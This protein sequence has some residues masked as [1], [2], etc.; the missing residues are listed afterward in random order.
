MIYLPYLGEFLGAAILIFIGCSVNANVN[1]SKTKGNGA[2]WVVIT[3]GWAVAVMVPV[4]IFDHISGAHFNP[5]VTIGLAIAGEFPWESVAL[6]IVCQMGGAIVGGI[7]T[8]LQFRLHFDVTENKDTQLGVFSTSPAIRSIVDNFISEFLGSFILVFAICGA[9]V[10]APQIA[11]IDNT[12]VAVAGIILAIGMGIGG[13]TG[14]A[15]NPARDLGPRIA[16]WLVPIKSKRNADWGYAWI[17]VIAPVLGGA[18][19]GFLA[20][21]VFS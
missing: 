21:L 7:L 20:Y 13:T 17:P 2:G 15:I 4:M 3:M 12:P 8:W 18:V 19:A 5:A 10:F 6:Y 9:V 14:Y 1:L 16:F 11:Q